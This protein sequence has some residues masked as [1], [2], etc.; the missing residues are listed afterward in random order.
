MNSLKDKVNY[1]KIVDKDYKPFFELV[2]NLKDSYED[3]GHKTKKDIA[4]DLIDESDKSNKQGLQEKD[5][6]MF[7][8]AL[9][10][11]LATF[12][13]GFKIQG[14]KANLTPENF[15]NYYKTMEPN[16]FQ[17]QKCGI[18]YDFAHFQYTALMA[19]MI[20]SQCIYVEVKDKQNK[21]NIQTHTFTVVPWRNQWIYME[22]SFGKL[23]GVYIANAKEDIVSTVISAMIEDHEFTEPVCDG[24][25]VYKPDKSF[26]GL[27]GG[28]Y[29]EK[30][31]SQIKKHPIYSH[32]AVAMDK[33]SK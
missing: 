33:I 31:R 15:H 14:K 9:Q 20:D 3:P 24:Y 32:K 2:M 18:C 1:V 11:K 26:Y 8:C 27:S 30:I 7:I 10:R 5:I 22:A 13:Y 17:N 25:Y 16:K 6:T 21:D 29:I 23:M 4:Y 19:A 12:E 28:A